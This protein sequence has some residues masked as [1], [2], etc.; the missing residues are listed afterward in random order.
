MNIQPVPIREDTAQYYHNWARRV[1][2]ILLRDKLDCRLA[3]EGLAIEAHS[4]GR[5]VFQPIMLPNTGTQFANSEDRQLVY[6]MVMGRREIP[7]A[8]VATVEEEM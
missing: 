1:R 5:A 3:P 7:E 6:D 4:V 8:V 2:D